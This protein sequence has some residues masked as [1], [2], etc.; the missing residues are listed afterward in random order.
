MTVSWD[1]KA[2]LDLANIDAYISQNDPNAAMSMVQRIWQ[3]VQDIEPFPHSAR[4]GRIRG[5]A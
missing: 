4:S 3:K 1:R 5:H 2:L